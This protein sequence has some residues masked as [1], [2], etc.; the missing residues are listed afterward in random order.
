MKSGLQRRKK[1][2]MLGYFISISRDYRKVFIYKLE[3]S[4]DPSENFY[5]TSGLWE[6]TVLEI[7]DDYII[8]KPTPGYHLKLQKLQNPYFLTYCQY[9][10]YSCNGWM[11]TRSESP[12]IVTRF[13]NDRMFL[14]LAMDLEMKPIEV[15][16]EHIQHALNQSGIEEN[17]EIYIRT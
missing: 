2:Y 12:Y 13:K 3:Y 4:I 11:Q 17:V 10:N 5:Q 9:D 14:L 8:L 1:P 16:L 15:K 6:P 7:K